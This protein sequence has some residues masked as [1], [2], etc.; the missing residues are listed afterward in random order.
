MKIHRISNWCPLF[1]FGAGAITLGQHILFK[2]SYYEK[3][4][5]SD[6]VVII[7]HEKVHSRQQNQI[8][9]IWFFKYIFSSKFR[10]SQEIEAYAEQLLFYIQ[11]TE[12][13]LASLISRM[14][15]QLSGR[16]YMY[17]VTKERAE[18]LL[19]ERLKEK[20]L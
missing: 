17:M 10:L 1:W 12:K 13:S 19:I 14:A 5:R 3:L 11:N 18:Q 7:V 4:N 9:W 8:G 20:G 6:L 16:T 2:N 15:K